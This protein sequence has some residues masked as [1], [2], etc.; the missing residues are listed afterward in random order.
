MRIVVD[1]NVI[2]SALVFGGLPRRVFETVEEGYCELFYSAEIQA[3]TRRVL[4]EKFGWEGQELD[5]Y[6]PEL[7]DL[8]QVVTPRQRINAVKE[9]PD[10]NRI[11]ECALASRADAIVSGDGHL[12]RLGVYERIAILTPRDFLR[13]RFRLAGCSAKR[14][15]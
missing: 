13:A 15:T 1:T 8:G 12:L 9:D 6:L 5:L 14:G 11:I 3:E 2:V 7:W 4:H 10:D